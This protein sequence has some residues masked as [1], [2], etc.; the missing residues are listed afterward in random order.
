MS[1]KA[2]LSKEIMEIRDG[3]KPILPLLEKQE[4]WYGSIYVERKATK[5]YAANPKQTQMSDQISQGVVLRIYDGYSLYEQATDEMSLDSIKK[6]A[7]QLAERVSAVKHPGGP[8]RPYRAPTWSERLSAKLEEEITSQIPPN[9]LAET[10][11]HFGIKVVEDPF[12]VSSA[13]WLQKLKNLL[14]RC[15]TL[16]HDEGLKDDELTFMRARQSVG[17]EECVFADRES[18]LSQTLYRLDL[19]VLTMSG[20][21]R[22]YIRKGGLGGL[23]AVPIHDHEIREI[24]R[25]LKALKG[26]SRLAPGKYRILCGPLVTGVLAH[27]AFGH[28]QEGDTCARG[29]SKAWE[30][31]K[32]G[33]VVGNEHATILNNPAIF[34]N[35][36]ESCAAWGS[37]FFD[38][39]GWLANEQVLLDRGVLKY[40]M[41]NLTSSIRLGVPRTA[42]GKRESWANGVYTRQTNTYFSAGNKTLAK[43]MSELGNGFV[44]VHPA[45]GMEDPKGMGIQVGISYL[46]EVKDGKITG[47][48]FK[49]PAGGDIQMTGYTPDIL[50]SIL[51]KSKIEVESKD[52]DRAK[53]PFNDSGGCGKYHKE[54][55]FAG[56]GGPYMLLD[57]VTLG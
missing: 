13:E 3:L 47:R 52:A 2:P 23:E 30:L 32:S 24:L 55:V 41:T 12:K 36:T 18:L 54:F 1:N 6:L 38:E 37:Y 27:E 35:G 17:V 57:Q 19:T 28:S 40:P 46:H 7:L 29:R 26:S 48:V 49:G 21:D 25:D 9:V 10:P 51:A 11:V 22:T 4:G 20:A 34:S 43:L 53:F 50:K 56:C 33:E 5:A 31:Q 39:E 42:N 14:E 8:K 16:A 15:K 44:A 45:G